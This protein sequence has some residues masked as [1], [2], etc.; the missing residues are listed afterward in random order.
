[1]ATLQKAIAIATLAHQ[2]QVDKTGE[3]Y[4]KHLLRVME[5]GAN[6]T[7]KICGVLHDIVEDTDWTFE[8]LAKEGFTNEIIEVLKCVTKVSDDEDYDLFIQRIMLN[9]TAVAVKLNDLK[10]N[11]DITRLKQLKDND[12]IRLNKYLKAYHQLNSLPKQ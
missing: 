11:M 5:R 2:N 6:E 7:E 4:I 3:P 12:V 8:A 9:K 10:D 1:M